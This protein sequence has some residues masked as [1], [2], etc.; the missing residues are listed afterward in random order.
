MLAELGEPFDSDEHLF[1]IKW[2]GTRTL[3][4]IEAGAVRLLNRRRIDTTARFPELEFLGGFP[5][6]TVLDG[7]LVVL[8][9]GKPDFSRLQ[10]REHM[11]SPLKIRTSAQ[12]MPTTYV[13]F[14]Q[15]Y[16]GFKSVMDRTFQSRRALLADTLEGRQSPRLLLSE[17]VVGPGREYFRQAVERGLEGVMA[18]RLTARYQAAAVA[19]LCD[20]RLPAAGG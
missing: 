14:D 17:G 15:L 18:K 19:G 3:A 6:G 10:S 8:A 12:A 1:E 7:E 13:V 4:F 20:H 16:A 2:D 9:G 5:A 11:T